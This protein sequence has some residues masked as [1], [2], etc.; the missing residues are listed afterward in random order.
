MRRFIEKLII[1]VL[2]VAAITFGV[3]HLYMSHLVNYGTMGELRNDSSYIADVPDH[4]Q[5]CDVGN[6]HS[7]YAF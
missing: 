7:Y 6:S 1:L 4:I 2:L 5:V 3:N